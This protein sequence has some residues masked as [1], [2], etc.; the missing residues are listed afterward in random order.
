MP[1]QPLGLMDRLLGV[2]LAS[3]EEEEN[4][5]NVAT[6]IPMLGLDGLS[7]AAYGPEAA[8][9][10]LLPLGVVGLHFIGPII[11]IILVILFMLYLS[12]RQTMEAYPSGG[13][14]YTVAKENLGLRAGLLAA[15][16]LLLDYILNVAVG[17]SAGV[18]NLVSAFPALQHDILPLCLGVLALITL[19]NLRGIRESG[20]A[21]ALPTYFFVGTLFVVIGKGVYAAMTHGGAPVP[22]IAPTPLPAVT[23]TVSLWL[24]AKSFASGCTAMTGVEAVANG[25]GAFVEPRVKNAQRTLT[26]IVVML[27]GLL[28]GIAYLSLAYHI[29]APDPD[30]GGPSVVSQMAAAVVGRGWFYYLTMGSVMVVLALSANTSFA[31][32]PR[33]CHL[34]AHDGF[35]PRIFV[36]RGRRLVYSGGILV[37][38]ALSGLLLIAFGGVTDRLIPLFAVGAFGAF[39]LSQAGMVMHWL[40]QKDRPSP[41]SIAVNGVGAIATGIALV[42][43]LAAKFLAGAWI[44]MLLIPGMLYLFVKT[45]EHY[46]WVERQIAY[47]GPLDLTRLEPPMVVV[48][49][50]SWNRQAELAMRFAA[51]ISPDVMGLHIATDDEEGHGARRSDALQRTWDEQVREPLI[52]EGRTPPELRIVPSPYRQLFK[53]LL[54]LLDE[55]SRL[56]PTRTTAVVIPEMVEARWYDIFLHNHRAAVFKTALLFSGRS[57]VA[58][59]NLPLYIS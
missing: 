18:E 3:H 13:G 36:N 47:S 52:Q 31:G 23:T 8:L 20:V 34:L 43:V 46:D 25:I 26:A 58:V 53:P 37:L 11:G 59:I 14:S 30:K 15:A 28:A 4:R 1:P 42:V 17:I 19:V 55:L 38:T 48:L 7:S 5:V 2:P 27:A 44:T 40:K 57:R 33:L 22:A 54:D 10:L 39:T 9:T 51:S 12:Y 16:S 49:V 56:H 35:L 29:G 32:F 21:F 6:G 45:R 24:L 50:N 41:V